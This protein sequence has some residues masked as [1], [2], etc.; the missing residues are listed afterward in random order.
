MNNSF[1]RIQLTGAALAAVLITGCSQK[2][3]G[4]VLARVGDR[5]I[6]VADFKAEYSRRQANRQPLPDRQVLLEQM[7]D[8]ETFLQQARAAGL[9]KNA[10]VRRA[11]EEI[12][13]AKFK[14]TQL[15][16]KLTAV[17]L[18]PGEIQAAYE[19]DSVRFT[20]PAKVKLAVVFIP[21]DEKADANSVAAAEARAKEARQ[22]AAALPTDARGFGQVAAEFSDDQATRYRGGDA[23]WFAMDTIEGRWPEEIVAAG[24]GL[25]N[26]GDLSGVLRAK[27]GFYLVKKLDARAAV[28][29]PLE[30]V[31]PQIERR[32]LLAKQIETERQFQTQ[33]RQAVKVSTDATLLAATPYPNPTPG[34]TAQAQMPAVTS[35]P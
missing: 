19:K 12:L 27:N 25:K 26:S 22:Q 6:T 4:D 29:T 7:I 10:E 32:L 28:V 15:E 14:E 11:T 13:L 34:K 2:P 9:D 21:V 20:Q 35:T 5:E 8:R 31:R 1:L 24:F 33:A 30:Q 17:T 16:P 18:T 3:A 23:G